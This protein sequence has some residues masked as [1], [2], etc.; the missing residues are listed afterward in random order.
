MKEMISINVLEQLSVTRYKNL[1]HLLGK[2]AGTLRI[3]YYD[4]LI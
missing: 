3:G 2:S 1:T 4:K